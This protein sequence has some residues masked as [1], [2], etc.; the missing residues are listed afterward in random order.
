MQLPQ[1][2]LRDQQVNIFTYVNVTVKVKLLSCSTLCDP[3]D[4]SLPGSS[5]QGIFQTRIL[6]WVS[7]SFSRRSSWPRD[8]T[9][10]SGIVGSTLLSEPP[11]KSCNSEKGKSMS[12]SVL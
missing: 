8:W 11:G 2:I 7:I 1:F 4:C 12:Y 6:E 9:W 3:T 10:V 5:I